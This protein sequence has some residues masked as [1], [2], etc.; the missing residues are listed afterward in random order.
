[1][2]DLVEEFKEGESVYI[3]MDTFKDFLYAEYTVIENNYVKIKSQSATLNLVKAP[4]KHRYFKSVLKFD[5]FYIKFNNTLNKYVVYD[6]YNDLINFFCKK[7]KQ[8][9]KKNI[10]LTKKMQNRYPQYF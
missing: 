5:G 9:P 3:L 10:K 4:K 2:L 6:D 1:M 7:L 8:N